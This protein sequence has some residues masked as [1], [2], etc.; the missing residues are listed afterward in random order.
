MNKFGY[1][2]MNKFELGGMSIDEFF[3]EDWDVINEVVNKKGWYEYVNC[4][5]DVDIS[6]KGD[7]LEDI[8]MLRKGEREF[9][10]GWDEDRKEWIVDEGEIRE[11][12]IDLEEVCY[13][14]VKGE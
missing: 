7:V 14:Y 11:D 13:V 4:R 6:Y 9:L 8:D 3:E 2:F 12:F 5:G 1:E 10:G